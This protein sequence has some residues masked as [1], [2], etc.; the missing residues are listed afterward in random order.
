MGEVIVKKVKDKW[1]LKMTT[2]S[3]EI[4]EREANSVME[5]ATILFEITDDLKI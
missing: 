5:I 2:D 3:G 1:T 4:I